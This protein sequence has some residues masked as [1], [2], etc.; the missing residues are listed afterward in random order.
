MD[1]FRCAFKLS[2]LSSSPPF[3]LITPALQPDYSNI[4]FV[5]YHEGP[6]CDVHISH[7]RDDPLVVWKPTG[8][9]EDFPP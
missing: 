5:N 1:T 6:L 9:F 4:I 7:S 8:P 2:N 3:H